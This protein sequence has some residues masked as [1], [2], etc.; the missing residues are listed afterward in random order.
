[1][2]TFPNPRMP[3]NM[4]HTFSRVP[5]LEI[6]RSVFDRSRTYKTTFDAG[7]LIPILVDEALPGD[8]IDID[9]NALIRLTTPKVPFMDNVWIDVHGFAAPNRILWNHWVN[10]MGERVSPDDSTEYLTPKITLTDSAYGTIYDYF[11]VR[12]VVNGS[13]TINNFFGRAMNQI[14]NRWYRDQNLQDPVKEDLGDGPDDVADY[15]LLKRGKRHDYFT[16]AL[17]WPQKGPGVEIPL[18]TAAPLV[19]LS[20]IPM[21]YAANNGTYTFD[22][23]TTPRDRSVG[24]NGTTLTALN[25]TNLVSG[26]QMKIPGGDLS[27]A[28]VA[29]ALEVDLTGATAVTINSLRQAFQLQGLYEIDARGGTRYPEM[30]LAHFGVQNPDMRMQYPEY[31]GGGSYPL[32]VQALA[33]TSETADGTPLGELAGV[34][35]CTIQGCRMRHSFTEHAVVIVL[36]SV[37]ADLT[38]Q[39]GTHRMFYRDTRFDYYTPVLAHLGEQAVL[40]QEIFTQGTSEDEDVFGYQ[41]RYAEY[42]YGQ[43]LITD[44]MRSDHPQSLDLWHLSQDFASLPV[45]NDEFI[46]EEPP[47]DRVVAVPSERQFRFDGWYKIKHVRPMPVYSVPGLIAPGGRLV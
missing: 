28:D 21:P 42:R 16:S 44:T 8:T 45:L 6:P 7:Y 35:S 10:F 15:Q 32:N 39:Q 46:E 12:P 34:G 9:I 41:E 47:M 3:S 25:T 4:N 11:G 30:I 24:W 18:G 20:D 36:L 26:M 37:R 27:G 40:N 5:S 13:I 19:G 33:Q 29:A 2:A 43:S 1:M 38:Y 23:G 22:D 14:W 17:P 31:I